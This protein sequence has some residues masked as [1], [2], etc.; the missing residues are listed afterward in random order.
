[1]GYKSIVVQVYD[2]TNFDMIE[3]D[4]VRTDNNIVTLSFNVAPTTNAYTY[5]IIG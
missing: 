3:C 1:M 4:V 5:V 2:T